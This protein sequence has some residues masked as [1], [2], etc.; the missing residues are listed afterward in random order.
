M[1]RATMDDFKEI[2][3]IFGM[4]KDVFSY[5]RQDYL[6]RRMQANQV[7]F[8]DGVVIIFGIYKRNQ[9]IGTA[10]AKKDD[11]MCYELA[12]KDPTK[13]KKKM[14]Q[15]INYVDTNVWSN[16]REAN[17]ISRVFHK[18]TGF[19]EMGQIVWKNGTIKGCVYCAPKKVLD[20]WK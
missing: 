13:A 14:E 15:F 4:Y 17:I 9:K 10:L 5:M 6:I 12:S 18:R 3:E 1:H 16:A 8:E 2:Q 20:I 7:I 19:V 11:V